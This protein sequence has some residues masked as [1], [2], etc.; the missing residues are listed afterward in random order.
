MKQ[1]LKMNL[2]VPFSH[3]TTQHIKNYLLSK[4]EMI[5]LGQTQ[6]DIFYQHGG[7]IKCVKTIIFYSQISIT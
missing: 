1:Y 3:L 7:S 4:F 2:L 5:D 6:N